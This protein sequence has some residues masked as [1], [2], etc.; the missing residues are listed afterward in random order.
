M[1]CI[2]LY[3]PAVRQSPQPFHDVV[4]LRTAALRLQLDL[5]VLIERADGRDLTGGTA[6]ST[7]ISLWSCL[8]LS[9]IHI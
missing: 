9:L 5:E 7:I 1:S 8:D 4:E 6:K 3:L 2:G